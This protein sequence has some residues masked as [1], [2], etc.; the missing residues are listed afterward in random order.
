MESLTKENFW[1]E[2]MEKYPEQMKVFCAWIHEYK[3]RVNW[4]ELFNDITLETIQGIVVERRSRK[5]H[6][7]PIAMQVG[8]FFQFMAEHDPD[9]M[10][11][12]VDLPND[13]IREYFKFKT[14]NQ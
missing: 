13:T 2:L 4:D 3:K 12:W 8:I 1:N 7:L 11:D 9:I 5:Y 14:S 6:E 10:E